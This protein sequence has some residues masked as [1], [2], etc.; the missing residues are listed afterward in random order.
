MKQEVFIHVGLQKTGTTWIQEQLFQKMKGVHTLRRFTLI[1]EFDKTKQKIIISMEWICATS[2]IDPYSLRFEIIER[3]ARLYPQAKIIFG[4]RE[5]KPWVKSTYSQ[6][7]KNGGV[8]SFNYWRENIF[9]EKYLNYDEYI[10]TLKKLFKEVYVYTFEDLKKDKQKFA[11][12]LCNFIGV[13]VPCWEE[14]IYNKKFSDNK[15]YVLRNLNKLFY[16]RWLNKKGVLPGIM[17]D[18]FR[19]IVKTISGSWQ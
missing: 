2:Y 4:I 19:Y 3:Y 8:E 6:Y 1:E 13:E 7:V 12:G 9:N 14:R 5:K 15:L 17:G 16:N 11:E 10:D 18:I